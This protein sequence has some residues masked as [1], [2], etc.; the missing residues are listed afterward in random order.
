MVVFLPH[1]Y[2]SNK[3]E[4]N[5]YIKILQDGA[6]QSKSKPLSFLW[7]QGGDNFDFE[8]SFQCAGGYPS[9]LAISHKK[10]VYAKLKGVFNK[11]NFNK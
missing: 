6:S 4:R 7:A 10:N 9:V 2:D 8:E 1:I 11:D 3:R 5:D